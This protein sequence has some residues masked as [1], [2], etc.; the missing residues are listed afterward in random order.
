M[1]IRSIILNAE[2]TM[3]HCHSNVRDKKE[4]KINTFTEQGHIK[5]IKSHSK[6]VFNID[7]NKN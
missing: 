3:I 2:E 6:N 7:H 4:T 5:L 1:Y